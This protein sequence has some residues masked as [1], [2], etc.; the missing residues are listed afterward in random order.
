MGVHSLLGGAL[1]TVPCKLAKTFLRP[2]GCTCTQCTHW[3][4][5]YCVR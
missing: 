1:T 4:R 3:L 2:E 5:L